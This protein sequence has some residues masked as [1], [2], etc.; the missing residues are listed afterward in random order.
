MQNAPSGH[1]SD[2]LIV[3]DM[4]DNLRVLSSTLSNRGYRVRAVRS[5]SM[6]LVGVKAAPPDLILLDVRMPEMDGFEVCQQLKSDPQSCDIPI[7]FLSASDEL[8]DKAKAFEVGG[9]DYITKPFQA[10]EVVTRVQNQLM[11]QQ[12]KKQ[13]AE[14]KQQLAELGSTSF[15]PV[16]KSSGAFSSEA[17]AAIET[18]VNY[19]NQLRQSTEIDPEQDRALKVIQENSQTL[20]NLVN[21]QQEGMPH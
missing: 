3:D 9:V 19:S 15:S 21:T 11:I 6:A 10:I 1:H 13:V 16:S 2:L 8:E 17:L 5:G 12:L 18:I 4:V 7:I 14:Q 20:L